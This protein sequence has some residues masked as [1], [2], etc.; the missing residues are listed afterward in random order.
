MDV[1]LG[2][3]DLFSIRNKYT[4]TKGLALMSVPL[5]CLIGRPWAFL[6]ASFLIGIS[7]G[8]RMLCYGPAVRRVAGQSDATTYFALAPVITLPLSAGIPLVNGAMLDFLAP[9]GAASYR[10]V[11]L[12]MGVVMLAGLAFVPWM[13][14]PSGVDQR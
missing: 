7:R 12:A 11:F 13:R 8:T 1:L 9:M 2:W 14:I 4:V 3:F 10:I 6:V 5:I